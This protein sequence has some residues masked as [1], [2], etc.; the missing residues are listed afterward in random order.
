MGV[1]LGFAV[2]SIDE[3][4]A[5]TFDLNKDIAAICGDEDA[6]LVGQSWHAVIKVSDHLIDVSCSKAGDGA[7]F[8]IN[9]HYELDGSASRA[10]QILSNTGLFEKLKAISERLVD[11]LTK[12]GAE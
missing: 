1:N 10:E 2:D 4:L 6:A 9:H 8:E 3:P 5:R 12:G 11:G 7:T